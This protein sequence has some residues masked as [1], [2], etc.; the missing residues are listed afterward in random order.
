MAVLC[1]RGL[2]GKPIEVSLS[3][4]PTN[5]SKDKKRSNKISSS[6]DY[7]SIKSMNARREQERRKI[8]EEMMKEDL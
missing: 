8:I 4:P 5:N 2:P 6:N 1:E 3:K 7:E